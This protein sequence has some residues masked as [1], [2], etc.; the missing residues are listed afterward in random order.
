M[1]DLF[2]APIDFILRLNKHIQMK[3][4]KTLTLKMVLMD[5]CRPRD[6]RCVKFCIGKAKNP[7]TE[8]ARF[9][10]LSQP[11]LMYNRP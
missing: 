11:K 10:I 7:A 8:I 3:Y 4:L 2:E 9:K 1:A 5:H 6:K